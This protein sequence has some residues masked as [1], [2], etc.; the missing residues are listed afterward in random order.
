[1]QVYIRPATKVGSY[2]PVYEFLSKKVFHGV[3]E[4]ISIFFR[5]NIY[6][7]KLNDFLVITW[8]KCNDFPIFAQTVTV[9][10]GSI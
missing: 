2:Y 6:H 8:E 3:N 4:F 9:F 10:S 5:V 1:M 7:G